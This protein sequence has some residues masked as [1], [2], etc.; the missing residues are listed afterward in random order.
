M[1]RLRI[2]AAAVLATATLLSTSTPAGAGLRIRV[3]DRTCQTGYLCAWVF[4]N[5]AGSGVGFYNTEAD[6]GVGS[7]NYI[8]N[9]SW[10]WA[11]SG[12][13]DVWIHDVPGN[14]DHRVE[15][16]LQ[17]GGWYQLADRSHMKDKTSANL[18]TP[19]C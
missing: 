12:V 5:F 16:C 19:N 10:S 13:N 14:Q 18:F 3:A 1:S 15:A 2:A 7:Y 6:W 4:D 9:N 17:S 8:N 11:N